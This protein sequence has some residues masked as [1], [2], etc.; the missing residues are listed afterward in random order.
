M[1]FASIWIFTLKLDWQLGADFFLRHLIDG[2]AAS[3]TLSWRWVGGLHTKGKTYLARPDNI[4]RY[5]ANHPRGPLAASGLAEDAP[6]LEESQEHHRQSLDLPGTVPAGMFDKPYALLLHDE[7]ASHV[8]LNLA[9]PA[10]LVIGAARPE[11][12][13]PVD[14]GALA[15]AFAR[16]AV[17]HGMSE[18]A[19]AFGCEAR[20]WTTDTSLPD[21]LLDAGVERIAIPFLPTGWT[22]DALIPQLE[23]MIDDGQAVVLLDELN[24]A[25]WPHAKAGF[26]G[27][28]KKIDGLLGELGISGAMGSGQDTLPVG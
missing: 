24:R 21:I 18:A 3:N 23:P 14:T 22:R 17:H 16:D 25:T 19:N 5:T 20:E 4:A 7:A 13:S 8:S 12:R 27:V 1:W 10:K 11:A 15:S 9:K 2:D 26:F 6:A 28:K